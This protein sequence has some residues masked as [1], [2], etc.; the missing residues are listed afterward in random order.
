VLDLEALA[1]HRGSVLGGLPDTPQPTQKR[2]DTLLWD[3]L[4]RFDPERPVFVESESR[5]VGALRVP[6]P[7]LAQ[8]HERGQCLRVDMP[9]EARV[10]LLME[11][12]AYFIEHPDAL[13]A[14]L[15]T[16]I[17]LRGKETVHRWQGLAQ[18]GRWPEL[19][20]D[21]MA[22]HYDP[23]YDKSIERSFTRAQSAPQ[24]HLKDGDRDTLRAAARA[25]IAG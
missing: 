14:Q 1:C 17:E 22:R 10:R 2:F 21:L 9:E 8:M 11:D 7:L 15:D 23:L 19:L 5:R 18:A 16:L 25:L 20:A 4:S 3:V 13:C 12:Y 6:E 24:M